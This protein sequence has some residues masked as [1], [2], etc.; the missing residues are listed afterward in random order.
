MRSTSVWN[1]IRDLALVATALLMLL[2]GSLVL[3]DRWRQSMSTASQDVHGIASSQT[4]SAINGAAGGLM[5]VIRDFGHDSPFLF[6]FLV[7]TAVL[8]V[9]ML[10]T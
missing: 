6:A 9:L 1:R 5:V 2:A 8:V 10:R 4:V 7:V 3:N